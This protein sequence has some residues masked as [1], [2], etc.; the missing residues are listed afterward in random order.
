MSTGYTAAVVDGKIT[1]FKDFAMLCAR[2]FGACVTMRDDPMDA[3]IPDEFKPSSSYSDHY[4]EA[5]QRLRDLQALTPEQAEVAAFQDYEQAVKIANECNARYQ[6]ENA[7]LD[8]MLK[9]V[10]SWQPPTAE[11]VEMKKFMA[12][13]LTISK[14]NYRMDDPVRLSGLEWL[15]KQIAAAERDVEHCAD[16]ARQENERAARRTAWVKALR[17]SLESSSS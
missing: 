6:E 14:T 1:E 10:A 4:A 12:D 5:Q 11:H 2:A 16:E 9:Q 3:E 13:Q 8:A 7:R 17:A 15:K